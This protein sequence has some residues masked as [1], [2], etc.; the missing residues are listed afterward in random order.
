MFTPLSSSSFNTSTFLGTG[1]PAADGKSV[2]AGWTRLN[3]RLPLGGP[4]AQ[5]RIDIDFSVVLT[6][7]LPP[8]PPNKLQ[9]VSLA[10]EVNQPR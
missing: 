2:S 10:L 7:F 4:L 5:Y 1:W 6:A 9:S 8:P 3:T